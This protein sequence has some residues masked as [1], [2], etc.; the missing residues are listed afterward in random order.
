MQCSFE[1]SAKEQLACMNKEYLQDDIIKTLPE[2]YY[3]KINKQII[4]DKCRSWTLPDNI[5][6]IKRYITEDIKIIVMV[7]PITEIV[8]SFKKLRLANGWDEK[9]LD[10]D[11]L[12][13]GSEPIM[14]SLT[15]VASAYAESNKNMFLFVEYKELVE[16]TKETLDNIYNFCGWEYFEHDL[17][18][19]TINEDNKE[20]DSVYGLVG[21]HVIRN[22]IGYS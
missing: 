20:N 6:L 8:D 3:K 15:G 12:N 10:K 5:E 13:P 16:N 2:S 17:E 21:Q 19:I 1:G 11:L 4:I 22:T 14:R 9:D 7:R 18:N